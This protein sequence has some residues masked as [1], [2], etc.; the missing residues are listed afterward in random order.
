M[1][2][3]KHK[4]NVTLV[5]IGI[6]VLIIGVIGLT[7]A[8]FVAEAHSKDI[9]ITSKNLTLKYGPDPDNEIIAT[10]IGPITE[11]KILEE[12]VKKTFTIAKNNAG[13]KDI[14]V[15]ID[16]GDLELSD[17]F[18][19]YDLKWA[20]YEGSTKL[21][22]GTFAQT[23][24]GSTSIN[25][26][27]NVLINSTTPKEYNLYIWINETDQ[28][29]SRLMAGSLRGK[30]KIVGEAVKTNTLAS[31]IL[32]DNNSNVIT[33]APNFEDG[34]TD[35]GLYVQK[36]DI[37]Q[38]EFGFPTY[39]YRGNVTNN[40]V[41]LGTYKTSGN[42]YTTGDPI[43]WRIVRINEDGSIKL[44]LDGSIGTSIF[45]SK[46]LA[47]YINSDG[48]DSEIKQVVDNWYTSNIT[49]SNIDSKIQIGDFCNDF[50]GFEE[51]LKDPANN[52]PVGNPTNRSKAFKCF[53]GAII[54]N[55]KAGM[56]TSDEF[57]YA[58]CPNHYLSGVSFYTLTPDLAT[59]IKIFDSNLGGINVVYVTDTSDAVIRPVINLRGD[60]VVTSGTGTESDP[61]V[62]Q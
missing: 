24:D 26:A 41:S 47:Q 21:T 27:N 56:I 11:D 15:R 31:N 12:A 1:E 23:L 54:A 45:N 40:Y 7:I 29:Q 60:V 10:D 36:D 58:Q 55:E 59:Y 33:S 62:I 37:S 18:K 16:L 4:K 3:K 43:I 20:L 48:T 32:G 52:P 9:T 35:L 50:S 53:N 30:V 51:Y 42:G 5:V 13:D 61:Y 28:D 2:E 17:N 44:I 14:Y 25:M 22:T 39:Y 57:K 49:E 6:I 38:T 8:Y 46:G 34:S 19:D